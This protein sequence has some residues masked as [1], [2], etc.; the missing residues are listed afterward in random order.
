M[1]KKDLRENPKAANEAIT[2]DEF[3]GNTF[4]RLVAAGIIKT[5]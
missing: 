4:R 1:M 3:L 2:R 5:K